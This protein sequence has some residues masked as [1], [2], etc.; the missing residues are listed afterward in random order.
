MQYS[1]AVEDDEIS[2]SHFATVGTLAAFVEGKL[3]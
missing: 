3:A 2:A 1:I